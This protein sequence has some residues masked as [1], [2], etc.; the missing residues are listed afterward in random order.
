MRYCLQCR[1]S[2]LDTYCRQF[3]AHVGLGKWLVN[4]LQA[5]KLVA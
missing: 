5:V 2:R 1:I 3:V 4:D